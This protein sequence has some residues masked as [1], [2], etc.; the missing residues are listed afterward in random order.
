MTEMEL[1]WKR[2]NADNDDD[3]SDG[4]LTVGEV[5]EVQPCEE[6]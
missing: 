1:S 2:K 5:G 3:K 4:S 6:Q